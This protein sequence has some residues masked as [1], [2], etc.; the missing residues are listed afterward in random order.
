MSSSLPSLPIPSAHFHDIVG[1]TDPPTMQVES[2]RSEE[3]GADALYG[4]G[5]HEN[6]T[7]RM[8]F[9]ELSIRN[10]NV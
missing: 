5:G 8:E 10:Q 9:Q 2:V 1:I 3:L 6:I 4:P 7:L